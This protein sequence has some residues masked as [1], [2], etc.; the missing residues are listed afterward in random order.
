MQTIQRQQIL[1]LPEI[2]LPK[3]VR[4]GTVVYS[5]EPSDDPDM[6]WLACER[7]RE[8]RHLHRKEFL[9]RALNNGLLTEV[10]E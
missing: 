5:I 10:G 7:F 6:A 8:L 3:K 4:S 1:I 9:R 2:Q